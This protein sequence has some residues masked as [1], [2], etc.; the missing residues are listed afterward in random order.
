M[1]RHRADWPAFER[2]NGSV[3]CH[4]SARQMLFI[5]GDAQM[6][7]QKLPS[8]RTFYLKNLLHGKYM[9]IALLLFL[10]CAT[11]QNQ[12]S[13][14]SSPPAELRCEYLQE[15]LGIDVKLPRLSWK[16]KATAPDQRGQ[17]QTAYRILVAG[18]EQ[19][20]ADDKGDLWD[21]GQVKSGQ[22]Q[23]VNYGGKPLSSGVRC[24]WKVRVRDERRGLSAWSKP[25]RWTM[26]L[27]DPSEWSAEWIGADQKFAE[28][29]KLPPEGNY[30]SDPWLRK[31]VTLKEKPRWAAI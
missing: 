13:S 21:S 11:I 7:I 26:G 16:L 4:Y 12:H 19:L 2:S 6:K 24:Y 5:T 10:G 14:S 31:V 18:A 29:K 25:A 8:Q 15:P 1:R 17:A 30:L 9:V 27:L 28:V 23:L 3:S 20:L 22:S